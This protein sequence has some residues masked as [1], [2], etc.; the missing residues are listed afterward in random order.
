MSSKILGIVLGVSAFAAVGC[1]G[2][3][4][5]YE[6]YKHDVDQLK[7]YNGT[8]ERDN[9]SLRAK[10]EAYDRLKGDSELYSAANKTYAELADSLKK[11]LLG[12]GVPESDVKVDEKGTVTFGTD[13]L[14]DLGSSTL[15]ARGK[16]ILGTFAKA[17]KGQHMRIVGHTDKK[18]IVRKPTLAALDTDTNT[19]LSVNRA[20][21]VMGELLKSGVSERQV[22]SVVG[23]GCTRPRGSDK[24][25]RRVEIFLVEGQAPLPGAPVKASFQK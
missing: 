17:Q 16:T 14:F 20:V 1:Q 11:A 6:Q 18:P 5:T 24:D 15:T 12:L 21:A 22:D 4:V 9:A 10:S 3:W 23:M 2:Q 25:S 13:V 8:L 19:E 7:E